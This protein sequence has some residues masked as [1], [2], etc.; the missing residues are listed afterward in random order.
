M[1]SSADCVELGVPA[2]GYCLITM[3]DFDLIM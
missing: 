1:L 3:A 2:E